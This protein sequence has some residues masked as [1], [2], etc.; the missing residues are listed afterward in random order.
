MRRKEAKSKVDVNR[1]IILKTILHINIKQGREWIL[2]TQIRDQ[3]PTVEHTV[4]LEDTF[5]TNWETNRFWR[6]APDSV[7]FLV[8]NVWVVRLTCIFVTKELWKYPT[9]RSYLTTTNYHLFSAINQN[10]GSQKLKDICSVE[11]A[12][13]QWTITQD[14]DTYKYEVTNEEGFPFMGKIPQ[15][16]KAQCGEP[17]ELQYI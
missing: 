11:R 8:L 16:W 2:V 14:K 12:V 9:Y 1:I 17:A 5:L 15:F 10:L 4:V 7:T 3:W 13:I 6:T